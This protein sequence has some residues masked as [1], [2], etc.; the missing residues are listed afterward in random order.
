VETAAGWT[1]VSDTRGTSI[2]LAVDFDGSG[3][4]EATFRDLARLLPEHLDIWHAVA[5]PDSYGTGGPAD[6][7]LTWWGDLP[8]DR[9]R[10]TAVLGYCAGSVF[11]SALAD[12]IEAAQGRRPAVLLFNPGAPSVDTV[13][14]DFDGIMRSMTTLNHAERRELPRRILRIL[15]RH[16]ADFE[17]VSTEFAALYLE[18]CEAVCGRLGIDSDLGDELASLFR[19]YLRYLSAARQLPRQPRWKSASSLCSREHAGT[20]FT[21]HEIVFD[22]RRSELL[23]SRIV[24]ET[25]CD[26]LS[27]RM[28]A[29]G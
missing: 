8:Q 9:D 20:H 13:H 2:V 19:S 5:P 16:G 18:A 3:R 26:I 23:R 25:A 22:L 28:M 12:R 24:A 17:R 7:Y 6:H 11:A 4:P 29:D 10:V 1:R 15:D 14:R 21:D 27:D